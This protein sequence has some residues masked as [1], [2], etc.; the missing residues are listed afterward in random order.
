M[1]AGHLRP[2]AAVTVGI[3]PDNAVILSA[4]VERD[5]KVNLFHVTARHT[6][7]TGDATML[8]AEMNGAAD[9]FVAR[10]PGSFSERHGAHLI[11]GVSP[12]ACYVFD[13]DGA[14]LSRYRIEAAEKTSS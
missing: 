2:G 8:Y 4:V 10:F 1:D 12:A 3:R 5:E 7:Q 14:A 6:Q 9:G 11:L 13:S